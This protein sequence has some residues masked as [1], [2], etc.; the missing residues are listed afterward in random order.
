M[1]IAMLFPGY[2]SQFVGMGKE[3]YDESRIMQEYF[4]EAS[5]CLDTNFV[6]L[7][8]ASSDAELSSITQAYT[9]LFLVSSAISA[10]LQERGIKPDLVAGYNLGEYAAILAAGGLSLP[11]GLY[12][13]NKYASFYN[14]FIQ[15]HAFSVIHVTGINKKQVDEICE[16]VRASGKRAYPA[17]HLSDKEHIIAGD[18]DAIQAV[19][20]LIM[21]IKGAGLQ[22]GSIEAGLHSP[23]MDDL[24]P[25]FKMYLEK[26]DFK[27]L[28]VP[29]VTSITGRTLE[30]GDKIKDLVIAY[31]NSP[32]LWNKVMNKL[33][34]YDAIIEVGPGTKLA[35]MVKEK[36]PDKIIVSVN[37][38]DDIKFL[39]KTILP[40]QEVQT[41]TPDGQQ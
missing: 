18:T 41:E 14:Q 33:D 31:I 17:A 3:L 30:R 2:G 1:K 29:L 34:D 19:R 36:Y 12:L 20:T 11:D 40:T 37:T 24:I 38:W 23:L 21:S 27:D 5:H 13:L 39:E 35:T 10:L 4:E 6:K 8:F 15:E 25:N 7:C 32:L 28:Q 22:E 9:A 16:Q 26:V